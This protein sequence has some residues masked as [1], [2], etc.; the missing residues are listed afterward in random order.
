MSMIKRLMNHVTT[1]DV[2]GGYIITEDE[3]LAEAI[4]RIADY[5]QAHVRPQSNVLSLAGG[6][7]SSIARSKTK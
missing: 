7:A 6:V 4:N 5:I 3:K 2:T 1:N